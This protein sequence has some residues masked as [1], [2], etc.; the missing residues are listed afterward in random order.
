MSETEYRVALV[1]RRTAR[2]RIL[3]L[4]TWADAILAPAA[5]GPAPRGLHATGTPILSRPWQLL[6][7]PVVTIPGHRDPHGMPLGLQ[8]VGHPHRVGRL[9]GIARRAEEAI[10]IRRAE[11]SA[12]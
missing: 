2:A 6:D 7:L 1:S 8:L 4:L 9:L 5:P 10:R 12:C 11:E 3:D